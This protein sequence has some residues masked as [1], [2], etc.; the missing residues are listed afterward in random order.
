MRFLQG[1]EGM[2]RGVLARGPYP[3]RTSRR[4]RGREAGRTVD[5]RG[6]VVTAEPA[7]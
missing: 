7:A 5:D 3:I 2:E 1:N 4:S 6:D